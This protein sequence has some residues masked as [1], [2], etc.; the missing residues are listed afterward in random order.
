MIF[1]PTPLQ[2]AFVIIP[3]PFRDERGGFVRAFC[4]R[5]LEEIGFCERIAQ[6]NQSYTTS[7]G[8]VRGLH[9]QH[10]PHGE[11]KFVRCLRGAA[12]DVIV[13]IRAGSPTFLQW[14]A[15]TLTPENMQTMFIPQ[16]FAHGFQALE[17]DTELLYLHSTHYA[18]GHEGGLRHDDPALRIRWPLPVTVLSDRDRNHPEIT[19]DFSGVQL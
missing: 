15:R 19:E 12:F 5:E 6:I 4:S 18:P 10:P 16:G 3:E 17:A 14:F 9:F 8:T 13:D 11:T 2:G 1:E 7:K